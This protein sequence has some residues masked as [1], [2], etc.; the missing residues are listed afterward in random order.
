[1]IIR[2]YLRLWFIWSCVVFVLLFIA[3]SLGLSVIDFAAWFET[4]VFLVIQQPLQDSI[5]TALDPPW[6][7]IIR[8]I[9]G[10]FILSG[11]ALLALGNAGFLKGPEIENKKTIPKPLLTDFLYVPELSDDPIKFNAAKPTLVGREKEFAEL[12][13][14]A[15]SPEAFSW[16]LLQ[17]EGGIGKSKLALA[18]VNALREEDY[19]EAGFVNIHAANHDWSTWQPIQK[20]FIVLDDAA[21]NVQLA[22]KLIEG[23]SQRALNHSVR[24]LLVERPATESLKTLNQK[25]IYLS[26]RY[27]SP[28]DLEP[29]DKEA[30][31]LIQ[32]QFAD[33]SNTDV[34]MDISRGIPFY[35]VLSLDSENHSYQRKDLLDERV[36]RLSNQL[37]VR[38][39]SDAFYVIAL[40]VLTLGLPRQAE[41]RTKCLPKSRWDEFFKQNTATE[42]PPL[43]PDILGEYVL[44]NVF[45]QMTEEE[46]FRFLK[47]AFEIEIKPSSIST[48]LSRL[49]IDFPDSQ[50]LQ[51]LKKLIDLYP[52]DLN[53][54]NSYAE[55]EVNAIGHY[56]DFW[57]PE[58]AKIS[59]NNL[60]ELYA[61][62]SSSKTVAERFA[63]GIFNAIN[64]FGE[65]GQLEEIETSLGELRQ[66]AAAHPMSGLKITVTSTLK[67]GTEVKESIWINGEE[68][69]KI[70]SESI[71][72][73]IRFYGKAKNFEKVE[74]LLNEVKSIV[75][76][77]PNN[78]EMVLQLAIGIH[79][80]AFA[81]GN[82][83]QLDQV[84]KLID[85]FINIIQTST[86][87][88]EIQKQF[89]LTVY[90]ATVD[91]FNARDRR[92]C[93]YLPSL[94]HYANPLKAFN[95]QFKIDD[96]LDALNKICLSNSKNG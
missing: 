92:I 17:G 11:G 15:S 50:L 68:V 42:I 70:L 89:A 52:L 82:A 14:F 53:V 49:N 1:M 18:W 31:S 61:N 29:L 19:Q 48:S 96:L 60:R 80:T 45:E 47:R 46:S 55:I 12:N 21:E 69:P 90:N 34:L 74:N 58:K 59:L 25:S 27:K 44:L 79:N 4:Q 63:N 35:A 2:F 62:H 5:R 67:M 3:H 94:Q 40:A 95:P 76:D 6:S 43:K 23:L 8:L 56:R 33:E 85:E 72:N 20:T 10:S 9:S 24:L 86:R 37:G 32:S 38:I 77:N 7:N 73:S 66:L 57:Q 26:N 87:D 91:F 30:I 71:A 93:K 75:Q 22:Q 39:E 88:N 28:K 51:R 36:E 84:E 83:G 13:E 41:E 16:W 54:V 65:A 78:E 64:C 81:Y